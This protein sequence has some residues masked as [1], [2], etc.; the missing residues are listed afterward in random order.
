MP[1][2]ALFGISDDG[3]NLAVNLLVLF[4]VVV[5]V[6]LIA[7]TYFDAQR[8]IEDSVLITC[9][10]AA[11]VFPYVGTIVYLILR[12][13]EYLE[14]ARERELEIRAAELRLR[15]LTEQAC[16]NCEYPVDRSYLR[17]PNCRARIKEPCPSC[18]KPL[19]PRWSICPFCE[20]P[21]R[22]VSPQR[23]TARPQQ[24]RAARGAIREAP[25][26]SKGVSPRGKRA[27][28]E[29]R[30]TAPARPTPRPRP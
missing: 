23:R 19:D 21:V 1:L 17:C 9:A 16:P 13:P 12:P 11:S 30:A 3:L 26:A 4:L 25:V 6:A 8:R 14:D 29:T 28:R 27:S 24:Q 5:W 7:W 22:A 20:T 18:S 15:Q 2:L 10:T